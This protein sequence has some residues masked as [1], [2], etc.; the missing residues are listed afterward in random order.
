MENLIKKFYCWTAN[1]GASQMA[2]IKKWSDIAVAINPAYKR[3]LNT[4]VSTVDAMYTADQLN[5]TQKTEWD[6]EKAGVVS[7]INDIQTFGRS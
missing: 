2:A 5:P 6:A 7:A 1:E 4:L 3:T